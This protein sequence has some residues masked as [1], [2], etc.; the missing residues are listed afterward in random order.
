MINVTKT[1]LPDIKKYQKYV[2]KIYESGWITNYGPLVR[3]LE[4]KLAEFLNVKHIVLVS[5]GTVALDVAYLALGLKGDGETVY[6]RTSFVLPRVLV[7][8]DRF[9]IQGNLL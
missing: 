1:Y 6:L 5:N 3:E 8:H 4:K 9:D 7:L 2:E